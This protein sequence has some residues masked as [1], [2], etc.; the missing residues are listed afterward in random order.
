[1]YIIYALLWDKSTVFSYISLQTICKKQRNLEFIG[2]AGYIHLRVSE[3]ETST[4][5]YPKIL[6][7]PLIPLNLVPLSPDLAP[8]VTWDHFVVVP[9]CLTPKMEVPQPTVWEAE[10]QHRWQT[11]NKPV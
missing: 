9:H 1:M 8:A 11:R 2:R 3:M 7:L 5:N 4:G 10:E 6:S